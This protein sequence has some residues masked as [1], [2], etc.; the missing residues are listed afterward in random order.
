MKSKRHSKTSNVSSRAVEVMKPDETAEVLDLATDPFA[1]IKAAAKEC[2]FPES[3]L[4][5]LLKRMEARYRPLNEAIREVK[6]GEVIKMLDDKV[7]RCLEYL[8]D[9]VMAGASARGRR[10]ARN[11]SSRGA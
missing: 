6:R 11:C 3:T 10:S 5:Q 2:G 8:D 1:T 7:V 9:F 4:R